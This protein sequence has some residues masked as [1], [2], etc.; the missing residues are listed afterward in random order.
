[1]KNADAAY[2]WRRVIGREIAHAVNDSRVALCGLRALG[3]SLNDQLAVQ[4]AACLK[5][6]AHGPAPRARTYKIIFRPLSEIQH[7]VLT[8]LELARERGGMRLSGVD[9]RCLAGLVRLRFARPT[10]DEPNPK[11]QI[12]PPG[13]AALKRGGFSYLPLKEAQ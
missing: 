2:E 13:R 3:W 6:V 7:D 9:H 8:A 5:I 1:M 4:C 12:E 11:W 10:S